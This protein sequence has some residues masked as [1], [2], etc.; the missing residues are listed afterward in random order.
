MPVLQTPI[1][2]ADLSHMVLGQYIV[3]PGDHWTENVRYQAVSECE[4]VVQYDDIH[5][6]TKDYQVFMEYLAQYTSLDSQVFS[7]DVRD[8]VV[9]SISMKKSISFLFAFLILHNPKDSCFSF[10]C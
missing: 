10:H 9:Y 7:Y 2:L 5:V 4:M 8:G 1:S 3:L 6:I